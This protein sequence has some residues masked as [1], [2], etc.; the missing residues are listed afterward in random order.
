MP[1]PRGRRSKKTI[2]PN[3]DKPSL[4]TPTKK[5]SKPEN[6]EAPE[7]KK[8]RLLEIWKNAW[9]VLGPII[10]LTG[11]AFLLWPQIK[12]ETSATLNQADPLNTQFRII[13]SGNVSVF[14]MKFTCGI[15]FGGGSSYFGD[16]RFD[17][18]TIKPIP[19]FAPGA[20]A[21]RACALSSEGSEIPNI[22]ITAS[23]K[24]P[25]IGMDDEKSA[26]FRVVRATNGNAYLLPD[27]RP[28]PRH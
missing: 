26:F 18:S 1:R 23:Y 19:R 2:Q 9:A 3:E 24:W 16:T 22:E 10:A 12:I 5:D 6:R 20:E 8:F 17:G 4:G 28:S 25:L 27:L 7:P 11:L 15:G 14:N 21:T 13:N